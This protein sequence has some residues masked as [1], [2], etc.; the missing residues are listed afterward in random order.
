MDGF[1]VPSGEELLYPEAIVRL[2]HA[3]FCY[4]PPDY[5]PEPVDPPALQRSHVTFGSFNHVAKIGDGVVRLWAD[6]LTANPSSRLILKWKTFDEP[7]VRARFSAAFAAHGVA[8]DRLELRGF[9]PHRAML[10]QYGDIDVA[11]DPFPFGGGLTSCEAL[12]MGVPVVTW[13]GD[14]PASRQTAAFLAS[15][16]LRECH[17][18]SPSDYVARATALASNPKGLAELRRALRARMAASPLCD[19]PRFARG[20]EAAFQRMWRRWTSDRPPEGFDVTDDAASS[21]LPA[22]SRGEVG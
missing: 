2:P 6:I 18:T 11:L 19:G 14:R 17:A 12:W 8:A 10:E 3:R 16:D 20:L 13:P 5:A 15:V 7:G 22:S 9:S 4:A 21:P 1:A